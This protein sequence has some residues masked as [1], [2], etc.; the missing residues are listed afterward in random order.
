LIPYLKKK[1]I[2][3]N[4]RA[5][6]VVQGVGLEF[7]PQCCKKNKNN[8]NNLISTYRPFMGISGDILQG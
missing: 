8:N 1:K 5:G 7:K 2:H 4:K 6:G 3:K